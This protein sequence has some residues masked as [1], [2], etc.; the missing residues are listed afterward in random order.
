METELVKLLQS[1][2]DYEEGNLLPS[3][4]LPTSPSYITQKQIFKSAVEKKTI[5]SAEGTQEL[6]SK[7]KGLLAYSVCRGIFEL[8]LSTRLVL[9]IDR[10]ECLDCFYL[11]PDFQLYEKFK[12]VSISS[13]KDEENQISYKEALERFEQKGVKRKYEEAVDNLIPK[14]KEIYPDAKNSPTKNDGWWLGLQPSHLSN[15]F[16]GDI[17]DLYLK[18]YWDFSNISH[19]SPFGILQYIIDDKEPNHTWEISSLVFCIHIS[20]WIFE[21]LSTDEKR[22]TDFYSEKLQELDSIVVKHIEKA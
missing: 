11:F 3:P 20:L 6:V 14:F 15:M 9:E 4:K 13:I 1:I 7:S 21:M 22:E 8:Y 19:P 16:G 18:K 5:D 12:K 17:L 10:E 2:I